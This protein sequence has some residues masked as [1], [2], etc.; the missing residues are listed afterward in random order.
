MGLKVE[1]GG[2]GKTLTQRRKGTKA[3]SIAEKS[4]EES[5]AESLRLCDFACAFGFDCEG[6]YF[7]RESRR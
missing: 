2:K 3:Q 7:A 1:R 5:F 4:K 6:S